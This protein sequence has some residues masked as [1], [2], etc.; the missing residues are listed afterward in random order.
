[1]E[2]A[3]FVEVH[4]PELC[5]LHSYYTAYDGPGEP[6][7]LETEDFVT[8]ASSPCGVAARTRT[9]F[10]PGR[11]RSLRPFLDTTAS[12]NCVTFSDNLPH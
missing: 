6:A 2:D 1:M 10:F 4:E 8:F 5:T 9:G 12:T 11:F 3:R 7:L